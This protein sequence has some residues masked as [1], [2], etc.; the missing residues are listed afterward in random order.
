MVRQ[1]KQTVRVADSN[2]TF[3]HLNL[4]VAEICSRKREKNL[5]R[6][7]RLR[8]KRSQSLEYGHARWMAATSSLLERLILNG[9]SERQNYTPWQDGE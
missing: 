2:R 6:E 5:T 3:S 8:R 7:R 4:F 9:I 1:T